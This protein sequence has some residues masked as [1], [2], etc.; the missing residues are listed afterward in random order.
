M[1]RIHGKTAEF[2]YNAISLDD[3]LNSITQNIQVP[4]QEITAFADA[5][6]NFVAGKKSVTTEVS[7][8]LDTVAAAGDVTIFEGIGAG[9]KSTVFDPSGAG[10]GANDPQYKCTASGLTGVL[11][12]S[13]SISLPVGGTASYTATFQHSASTLRATS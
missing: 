11:V 13:Y 3:E 8:S 10:P 6:Q 12:A 2:S 7:G 4:E 1:A 9:V 5:G